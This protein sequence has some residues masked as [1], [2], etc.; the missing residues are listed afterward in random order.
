MRKIEA[1]KTSDNKVFESKSKA[2]G[3]QAELEALE[4]FREIY[5]HGMIECADDIICFLIENKS[6]VLNFYGLS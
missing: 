3:H 4:I 1:W 2:E 6:T 5:F